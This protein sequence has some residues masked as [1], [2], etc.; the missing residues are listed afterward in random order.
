LPIELVLPADVDKPGDDRR[1]V[2]RTA[3][4]GT[5]E[6]RLVAPNRY[7]LGFHSTQSLDGQRPTLPRA[8]YPGVVQPADASVVVVAAG[9]R[10]RLKDFV[11]PDTINLVTVAGIVVDEAGRVVQG[12]RV[13]VH[14]VRGGP[15]IF[16]HTVETGDDGRFDFALVDRDKYEVHVTRHV[17]TDRDNLVRVGIVP[18]TAAAGTAVT[19]VLK[20]N[21]HR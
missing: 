12:A 19:V 9:E 21:Q 15:R 5:F 2:A 4:D 8:F 11:V 20:P 10:V 17:A 16:V 18:F 14:A 13:V 3:A 1:A 7:L 6:M